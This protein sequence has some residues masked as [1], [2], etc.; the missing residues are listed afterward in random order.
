[1]RGM[2]SCLLLKGSWGRVVRL[3]LMVVIVVDNNNK[4]I[5]YRSS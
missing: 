3:G 5:R 2:M 4:R 1:M